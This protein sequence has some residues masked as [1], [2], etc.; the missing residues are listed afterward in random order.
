MIPK[1]TDEAVSML[2]LESGRAELLEEI[3][4]AVAP[5]RQNAEPTPLP[6]RHRRA[7]WLVPLAVAAAVATVASSPLWWG[8]ADKHEGN[9]ESK[10]GTNQKSDQEGKDGSN[11]ET[12]VGSGFQAAPNSPGTG[13]R[14][15]VTAPGWTADYVSQDDKYGGEVQFTNGGQNLAITW[16]PEKTYEDYL[17]DREHITQPPAPGD[18]VTV[19]GKSGQ[20]WPYSGTDHTVMR[21]PDKGYWMEFRGN[22][23]DRA[24]FEELLTQ[25]RLVSLAEFES[26]LP[27][28]FVTADD[29]PAAVQAILDGIE[30]VT[31]VT[32][33][34]GTTLDTKSDEQDPYQLGADISGQYACSWINEFVV[35]TSTGDQARAD[36]AARV[37]GTS[38]EWPVLQEMN[39]EGDYPEVVWDYADTIAA[40][41]LPGNDK[42]GEVGPDAAMAH[43]AQGL[44]C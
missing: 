6:D 29:R 35:A 40:G 39:A 2:P 5:D 34:A 37:M 25:L 20:L 32:V 9:H 18:P 13:Y 43:V 31:G 15:V 41:Q 22:G 1:L 12:Q 30:G 4:T 26:A 17:L 33:P 28:S 21:E 3:M 38:R 14:A 16:Y 23:M 7:R 42:G 27:S 24:A 10:D 11:P 44:G 8:D 19:L 36:E